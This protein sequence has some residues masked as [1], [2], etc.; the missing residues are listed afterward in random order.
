LKHS[1]SLGF[2]HT[3]QFSGVIT[4]GKGKEK[5]L[6]SAINTTHSLKVL[7]HG[8]QFY[9]QITPCLPFL[10]KHSADGA[11]PDIGSRHPIAAYYSFIDP[12]G[13][14]G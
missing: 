1:V 2:L 8:S 7:R 4:K 12:E 6:Y 14:K 9:L 5:Y 11:T 13:M 3:A 10:C